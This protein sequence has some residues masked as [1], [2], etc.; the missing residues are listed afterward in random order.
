MDSIWRQRGVRPLLWM[1]FTGFVGYAVLL[2]VAPLWV[3]HGGADVGRS[4]LVN[5]VML[6]ATVLTQLSMPVAL[7]HLSLIHI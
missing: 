7:R 6:T 4:G 3:V 5:G 1:T 2:P